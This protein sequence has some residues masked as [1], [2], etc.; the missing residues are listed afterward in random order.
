[1]RVGIDDS[2]YAATIDALRRIVANLGGD[3][4]LPGYR[5]ASTEGQR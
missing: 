3:G 2:A 1:M 5:G 4:D